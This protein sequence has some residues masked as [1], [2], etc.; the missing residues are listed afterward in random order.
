MN[1]IQT[2]R[3]KADTEI[4]SIHKALSTRARAPRGPR[5]HVLKGFFKEPPRNHVLKGFFKEPPKN[6]I[7]KGFFKE[8]VKSSSSAPPGVPAVVL[9]GVPRKA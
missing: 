5:N 7:L 6:H 1:T 4:H 8:P 9:S 2:F 3:I